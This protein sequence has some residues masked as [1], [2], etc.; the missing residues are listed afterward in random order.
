MREHLA[1]FLSHNSLGEIK[2]RVEKVRFNNSTIL[3]LEF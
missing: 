3:Y 1:T 2:I